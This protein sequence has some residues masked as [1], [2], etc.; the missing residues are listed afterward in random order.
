MALFITSQIKTSVPGILFWPSSLHTVLVEVNWEKSHKKI[1]YCQ[2][3]TTV[4]QHLLLLRSLSVLSGQF[5]CVWG[6]DPT[7]SKKRYIP[8]IIRVNFHQARARNSP[9]HFSLSL[10]GELVHRRPCLPPDY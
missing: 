7:L 8:G 6:T 2:H 10:D 4:T 5:Y 3:R 1:N 9:N